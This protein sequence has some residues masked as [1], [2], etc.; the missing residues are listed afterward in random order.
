VRGDHSSPD[1]LNLGASS[2]SDRP[3]KLPVERPDVHPFDDDEIPDRVDGRATETYRRTHAA[4]AAVQK[5]GQEGEK[6]TGKGKGR[7]PEEPEVISDSDPDPI[8]DFEDSPSSPKHFAITE[9]TRTSTPSKTAVPSVRQ[10]TKRFEGP[11]HID[12]RMTVDPARGAT[13]KSLMKPKQKVIFMLRSHLSLGLGISVVSDLRHHSSSQNLHKR[14]PSQLPQVSSPLLH[15][16]RAN[17]GLLRR[18]AAERVKAVFPSCNSLWE[19]ECIPWSQTSRM[20]T[21]FL[22]IIQN[23][24]LCT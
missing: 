12:L 14:I 4:A 24:D 6:R 8:L 22:G 20:L 16:P 21:I 10:L 23:P 11:P 15:F 1:P 9:P 2:R 5:R 13:M 19:R 3:R 17:H 18:K 7:A